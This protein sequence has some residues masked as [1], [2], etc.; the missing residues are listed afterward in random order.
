MPKPSIEKYMHELEITRVRNNIE[1][2]RELAIIVM[3]MDIV[4][5]SMDLTIYAPLRN[6]NISYR[7]LL[8]SH[9]IVFVLIL[10]WLGLS[11]YKANS[12]SLLW[13]KFVYHA[14]AIITL[15]WGVFLGLNDLFISGQI[16]AFIISVFGVSV[17]LCMTTLEAFITYS[18]SII[19]FISGLIIIVDNTGI[20]LSHITNIIVTGI[21]SFIVSRLRFKQFSR[22]FFS[23]KELSMNK[24]DIEEA[25]QKLEDANI[26]L[27]NEIKE[28]LIAEEKIA[29][30]IYY[31]A[32]TG[33]FNRKKVLEDVHVLL[34]NNNEKFA[35]LFIDLDKFKSIND[36]YGHEAGDCV[37][38]I[39]AVRL[40]N[41]ISQT[42]T[43]SRI[44]G[45]EFIIILKDLDE[46]TDVEEIAR[47]IIKELSLV[48]TFNENQFCIGASIGISMFPKHGV[49]ADTLINK[50]DMAMYQVKNRG[51]CGYLVF[52]DTQS[53]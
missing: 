10:F 36:K 40:R 12:K 3:I 28:R 44:G 5:I 4:L 34:L 24:S 51:G 53:V 45:D 48:F 52:N 26:K 39:A 1:K 41:I 25:Y 19:I 38:K 29:N 15:Y 2:C 46:G 6:L 33:I 31:D 42:D 23:N 7:Y 37:L 49:D 50:A 20:L 21:L 8:Y 9:I 27:K 14:L 13:G 16:S 35:V 18:I 22:N 11:L 47:T 17:I 30:L 32:L 43:I